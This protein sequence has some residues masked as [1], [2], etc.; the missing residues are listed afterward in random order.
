MRPHDLRHHAATVIARNPNV[1]LSELM[2]T[3]G[4]SSHAA[5]LRYQHATAERSREIADYL[6]DV[7]IAAKP[8]N[9]PPE[10]TE[11]ASVLWHG[12]GMEQTGLEPAVSRI[13]P[14]T[15]R[16]KR[17]GGR[18]RTAVRGFAGPCLN[19]SATPP[20][21][22]HERAASLTAGL[23]HA[24]M[25]GPTGTGWDLSVLAPEAGD[26]PEHGRDQD[27]DQGYLAEEDEDPRQALN[28]Q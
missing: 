4:H 24:R 14:S 7:I 8:P 19:H 17:G 26:Q 3:I 9:P 1:T 13:I 2:A 21:T 25:N 12:C 16:T 18:N 22:R 6:D 11:C 5:A 27:D 23:T 20:R 10:S 15:G 28:I